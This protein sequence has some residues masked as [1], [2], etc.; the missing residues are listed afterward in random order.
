MNWDNPI[1]SIAS[2]VDADVLQV[3]G[4]THTAVTGNQLAQLA[5]RS[6]SQVYDVVDRLVEQG[7]VDVEQHGRTYSYQLNRD[8]VLADA[9]QE[10]IA[11]PQRVEDE[12][13]RLVDNWSLAPHTVALFGSAARRDAESA[14]DLDLLIIREN[15]ISEDD[16]EW[17][18]QTGELAQRIERLTGNRLQLVELTVSEIDEALRSDQPLIES[19]RRDARTLAGEDVQQLLTAG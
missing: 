2:T 13:R 3:L 10:I 5:G 4:R 6:Y 16:T 8:H 11:A 7:V 19:I 18:E 15:H 17:T 14:S 1:R 9:I 12:I